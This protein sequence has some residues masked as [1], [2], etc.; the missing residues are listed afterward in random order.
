MPTFQD[1]LPQHWYYCVV[2]VV[3]ADFVVIEDGNIRLGG[4]LIHAKEVVLYAR[5]GVHFGWFDRVTSSAGAIL[6]R[7]I[8]KFLLDFFFVLVKGVP[9]HPNLRHSDTCICSAAV[10]IYMADVYTF[11]IAVGMVPLIVACR[12]CSSSNMYVCTWFFS[13]SSFSVAI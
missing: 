7:T 9:F 13:V 3:D 8:E 12:S 4:Q 10:C 2:G 5:D 6:P 11:T 1:S